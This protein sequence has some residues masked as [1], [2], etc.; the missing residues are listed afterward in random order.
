MASYIHLI[1]HGITEGIQKKCFYGWKDL[2]VVEEGFE[3]LAGLKEEGIYPQFDIEDAQ[4]FTS[5]LI[6]SQQTL[7]FIYGD[8][9]FTINEKI[10]EINFGDW[11]MKTWKEL[12]DT[13]Q[14]HKW[15]TD[16]TGEFRFP[17]GDSML[18][19]AA[20]VKEGMNEIV[21]LHRMKELS[22]RHSGKDAVTVVVCHGGTIAGTMENWFPGEREYFMNW[23]PHTG[24][25]Y[26]VE[27]ENSEPVRFTE[28]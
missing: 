28:I 22:H 27:F 19:F 20:R 17:N 7:Q 10:K 8:V 15:M 16:T 1:R 3:E 13:E 26:T 23:T 9:D 14:W 11:E 5:D 18:S 25:G 12:E 2:P 21:G 4:F 6:R 24:R